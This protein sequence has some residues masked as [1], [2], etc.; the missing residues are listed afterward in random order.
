MS[1]KITSDKAFIQ[2]F[3]NSVMAQELTDGELIDEVCAA[4]PDQE[5]HSW[6]AALLYEL[7]ARFQGAIKLEVTPGGLTWDG[8]KHTEWSG[9]SY[10]HQTFESSS[11]DPAIT[12]NAVSDAVSLCDLNECTEQRKT[13]FYD[14]GKSFTAFARRQLPLLRQSEREQK[15]FAPAHRN[16]RQA[17]FLMFIDFLIL[18]VL[19]TVC[20]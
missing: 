9:N 10:P 4:F 19:G 7:M 2:M 11:A 17:I 13:G 5:I 20:L 18:C 16:A 14:T 8:N 15:P 12:S 1:E 3:E 6:E